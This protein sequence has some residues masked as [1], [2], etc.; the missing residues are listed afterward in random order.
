V[1]GH[2]VSPGQQARSRGVVKSRRT[3]L[4]LDS[5]TIRLLD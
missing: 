1:N 4:L 5:S 2:G 3:F